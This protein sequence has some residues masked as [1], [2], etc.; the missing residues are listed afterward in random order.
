MKI[1]IKAILLTISLILGFILLLNYNNNQQVL[2]NGKDIITINVSAPKKTINNIINN[3][4]MVVEVEVLDQL[5]SA[6][7]IFV[8]GKSSTGEIVDCYAQRSVKITKIYLSKEKIEIGDIIKIVEPVAVDKKG[9]VY[10]LN[11]YPFAASLKKNQIITLV[12]TKMDD[13]QLSIECAGNAQ[14]NK[15]LKSDYGIFLDLI[16]NLKENKGLDLKI[17]GDSVPSDGIYCFKDSKF[18]NL[19]TKFNNYS[20]LYHYIP[21]TKNTYFE[22]N[23][24]D[25]S[26][27]SYLAPGIL[28][29]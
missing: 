27:G 3:S 15:E 9:V 1:N 22:I 21:K 19:T 11:A 13:G 26:I 12:L 29:K 18:L 28:V 25:V 16:L 17:L 5:S 20:I 10:E 7:S 24:N 23:I 8:Y 6:N 4:S 14:I 2:P